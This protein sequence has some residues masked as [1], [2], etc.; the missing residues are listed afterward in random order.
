MG[1]E[2]NSQ[3]LLY[4]GGANNGKVFRATTALALNVSIQ[5]IAF[6]FRLTFHPDGAVRK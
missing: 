1:R 4:S 3:S 5:N 6:K 2:Q